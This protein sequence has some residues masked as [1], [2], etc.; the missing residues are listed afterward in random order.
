[1][2]KGSR[3]KNRWPDSGYLLLDWGE[4]EAAGFRYMGGDSEALAEQQL[5]QT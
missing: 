2:H 3:N 5:E 1:M 4:Q